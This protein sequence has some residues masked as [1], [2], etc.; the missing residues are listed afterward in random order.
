[1]IVFRFA[2]LIDV[3]SG[4][5][6]ASTLDGRLFAVDL[7]TGKFLSMDDDPA[8]LI[9]QGVSLEAGVR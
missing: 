4:T 1:M 3:R 5:L 9:S 2:A 7:I 6:Y 8:S